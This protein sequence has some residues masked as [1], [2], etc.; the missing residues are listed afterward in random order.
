[1]N[2]SEL[3]ERFKTGFAKTCVMFLAIF[4]PITPLAYLV[5][6][7]IYGVFI[8]LPATFG[9]GGGLAIALTLI[10][11]TYEKVKSN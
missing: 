7:P 6:P 11:E 10:I 4:V 1:M 2:N 9:V 8:L 3:E 5:E